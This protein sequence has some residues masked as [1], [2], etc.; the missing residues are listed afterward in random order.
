M[1][2]P[3][4]SHWKGQS[5]VLKVCHWCTKKQN[6]EA[7]PFQACS[8]CKEVLLVYFQNRSLSDLTPSIFQVIYCVWG[9]SYYPCLPRL[10]IACPC[11]S[12][13][14]QV[15][16]WPLHKVIKSLWPI[17]PSRPVSEDSCHSYRERVNLVQ[18]QKRVLPR[19]PPWPRR[20]EISR[21]G[22]LLYSAHELTA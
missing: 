8:R 6:P 5:R 13:E 10:L 3:K 16:S 1:S 14:C 9:L 2:E 18:S 7:K 22:K 19:T 20:L 17:Y 21:N 4:E 12:K 11:Q 15:A